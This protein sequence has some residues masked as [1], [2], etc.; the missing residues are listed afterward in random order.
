VAIAKQDRQEPC[1]ER[2]RWKIPGGVRM[3]TWPHR[4]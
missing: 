3:S 2:S 1:T 4:L